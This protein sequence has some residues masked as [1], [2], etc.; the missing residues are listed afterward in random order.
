MA[1]RLMANR[2]YTGQKDMKIPNLVATGN[3]AAA[4]TPNPAKSWGVASVTRQGVGKYTLQMGVSVNGAVVPDVYRE[5]MGMNV[6]VIGTGGAAPAVCKAA[7]VTDSTAVDGTLVIQMY[8][9][10]G[11]AADL[12]A[13]ETLLLIPF[14]TDSS[15]V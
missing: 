8:S 12:A 1:M 2:V 13:N 5:F 9:P 11:A 7:V 14:F 4:P 15:A 10:A 3:G 6:T